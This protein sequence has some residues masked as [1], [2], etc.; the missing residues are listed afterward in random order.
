[1]SELDNGPLWVSTDDLRLRLQI[2]RR[3]IFELKK[4]GTFKPG[5][6]YRQG[7]LNASRAISW[8]LRSCDALLRKLEKRASASY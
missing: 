7:G 4:D 1:M 2:S 6:H 8:D 3:R 5:T